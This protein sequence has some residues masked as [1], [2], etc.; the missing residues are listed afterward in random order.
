ML[1]YAQ[2]PLTDD[3]GLK[4][5]SLQWRDVTSASLALVNLLSEWDNWTH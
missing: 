4:G 5:M 3:L 2:V 1:T